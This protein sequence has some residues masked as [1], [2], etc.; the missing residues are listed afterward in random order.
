MRALSRRRPAARRRRAGGQ[1]LVEVALVLPVLAVLLVGGAQIGALLYGQVTLDTATREGARVASQHPNTSGAFNNGAPL[2]VTKLTTA[3]SRGQSGITTLHVAPLTTTIPGSSTVVLV[4]TSLQGGQAVTTGAAPTVP[5]SSTI[6]VSSFTAVTTY[7]IG[8]PV[9]NA[10]KCSSGEYN[11]TASPSNPAC[12]AVNQSLGL[13]TGNG[14]VNTYIAPLCSVSGIDLSSLGVPSCL[15]GASTTTCTSSA[16]HD[17]DLVVVVT[18][19]VPVFVPI[20]GPLLSTP[21]GSGGHTDIALVV[22]RV[23]PCT[24]NN[25]T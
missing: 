25:G 15:T 12:A 13:L 21:G 5:G 7:A 3:I 1:A 2:A 11:A 4:S 20:V 23:T 10:H 19:D 8:A 14:S 22:T 18:Y 9:V 17:G 6:T 16:V 24:M